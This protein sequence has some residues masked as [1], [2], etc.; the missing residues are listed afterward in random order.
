MDR[1]DSFQV[2]N[3]G[4]STLKITSLSTL[5]KTSGTVTVRVRQLAFESDEYLSIF[6]NFANFQSMTYL[7]HSHFNAL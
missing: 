6:L 7:M 2:S 3:E 1:V 4:K 5:E